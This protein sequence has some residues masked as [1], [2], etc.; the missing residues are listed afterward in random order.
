MN[1]EETPG[2]VMAGLKELYKSKILPLEESSYFS[3]FGYG[4]LCDSDFDS[5]PM[6]LLVGPYSSGKST[7]IEHIIGRPYPGMKVGPEP[8]TDTFNAIM[9]GSEDRVIPGNALAVTPNTPFHGLQK[10]GNSFLTRFQGCYVADCEFLRNITII[11]TPGILSGKKQSSG[12]AYDYQTVLEWFVERADMIILLFDVQKLDISDEMAAAVKCLQKSADKIRV[13]MNKSD[14]ISHQHLMKVYGAMLWSLG[15]IITTP[16]VTKVY[17]GSFWSEPLQNPETA[18]LIQKE[19]DDLMNDVHIL[20]KMGVIRKINDMVKRIRLVR[21]QAI[22]LDYL[23]GEMPGLFGKEKKKKELLDNLPTVF[24]TV[25]A[26][27]S[28]SPGDFPD[29]QVF[30]KG[31]EG[32]DFKKLP[33]LKGDRKGIQDLNRALKITIPDLMCRLPGAEDACGILKK[34]GK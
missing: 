2:Q 28:L 14:S 6:V 22:L 8:T 26:E 17:I 7:F 27:H 9:L 23:R 33:N 32:L 11:D 12:R 5:N 3:R 21:V 24:R 15:R 13:V 19:M 30:R 25:M 31:L 29:I 34:E 10:F 1:K 16:E 20:P 4:E 18:A